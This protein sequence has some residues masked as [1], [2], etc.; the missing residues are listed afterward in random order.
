MDARS[1]YE[2]D[3]YAW[4][5]QQAA[6]LRRLAASR[7]DLPNELD[8]EHVAE[9]I[10][11]LGISERH[12]VESF[13]RLIF[14]HLMKLKAAPGADSA[15]S[16]RRE[17]VAFHN[18]LLSRLTLAMRP[19]IDVDRLW[20]RALREARA[21]LGAEEIEALND[22]AW[23]ASRSSPV[24]ISVLADEEFD[25]DAALRRLGGCSGDGVGSTPS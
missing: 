18:E 12:A 23:A 25:I 1:L 20:I 16:W 11:D 8:L 6:V 3:I 13:I 10:E 2:E 22:S 7:R 21:D 9:E 14:V 19:R 5:E 24:E 4:A 15:K 17:I